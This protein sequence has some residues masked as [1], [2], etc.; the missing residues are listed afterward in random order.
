MSDFAISASTTAMSEEAIRRQQELLRDLNVRRLQEKLLKSIVGE[1]S[2]DDSGSFSYF[3][4]QLS[5]QE[6]SKAEKAW[7][8]QLQNDTGVEFQK[9]DVYSSLTSML[10]QF[11][12]GSS[13]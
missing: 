3:M 2:V 6:V 1:E 8:A 4:D 7:L 13:V 9:S 5:L 11:N 12:G 10:T